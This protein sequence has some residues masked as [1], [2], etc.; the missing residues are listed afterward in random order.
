MSYKWSNEVKLDV[1]KVE[2]GDSKLVFTTDK[3][4]AEIYLDGQD[5]SR[6]VHRSGGVETVIQN[7]EAHHIVVGEGNAQRDV[8]HYLKPKGPAPELRIGITKHR[9][10][11]TW[12]SLPH[13]FELNLEPGFEE[14]FFYLIS[15]AKKRAIQVG[16]GVWHDNSPVKEA[17]FVED[18]TFGTI[19][20]GYHPVVAEPGST[21]HYVWAYV[22]K[23]QAWEKI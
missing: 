11:G 4:V 8:Y 2:G 9:G 3:E 15:G 22:C 13:D 12:S 10:I 20:M 18:H 14:V 7:A 6:V 21:V 1:L 5:I 19:P 17:W 16:E 23:K